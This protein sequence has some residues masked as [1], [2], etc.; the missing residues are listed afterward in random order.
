MRPELASVAIKKPAAESS[1]AVRAMSKGGDADTNESPNA[2][3]REGPAP[4]AER[5]NEPAWYRILAEGKLRHEG[6]T[7]LPEHIQRL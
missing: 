6:E 3:T 1:P 7:P 4:L 5:R 2:F